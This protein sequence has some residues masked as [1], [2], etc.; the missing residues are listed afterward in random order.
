M[1]SFIEKLKNAFAKRETIPVAKGERISNQNMGRLSVATD[2]DTNDLRERVAAAN[3]NT[4]Q[5]NRSTMFLKYIPIQFESGAGDLDNYT[6]GGFLVSS[7]YDDN[8]YGLELIDGTSIPANEV[9]KYLNDKTYYLNTDDKNKIRKIDYDNY[10]NQY[11]QM[12][13]AYTNDQAA[14]KSYEERKKSGNYFYGF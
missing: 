3:A 8:V 11:K 13:T 12:N 4:D 2:T 6:T 7:S 1:S 5:S 14:K 10:Q 9:S